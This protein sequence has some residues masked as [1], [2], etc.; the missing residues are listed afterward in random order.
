VPAG[1]TI[2]QKQAAEFFEPSCPDTAPSV[3]VRDSQSLATI[4]TASLPAL[5]EVAPELGPAVT[6][7]RIFALHGST[8]SAFAAAGCG[9]ATCAPAANGSRLYV[10]S[11]PN[12]HGLQ[13]FATR[14][15]GAATCAPIWSGASLSGGIFGDRAGPVVAGGVVYVA[16]PGLHAYPA[17][18][19][20]AATCDQIAELP[21]A[22]VPTG[23]TVIGGRLYVTTDLG[24]PV[25]YAPT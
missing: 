19:C 23:V 14:G 17:A 12:L 18:G 13:V 7:G 6:E 9:E 2:V 3:V 24:D 22:G 21:T 25:A 16:G 5:G 4:W 1:S 15:C 8:L 11:T 10:R 20:G